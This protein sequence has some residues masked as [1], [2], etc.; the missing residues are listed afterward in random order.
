[1][2]IVKNIEFNTSEFNKMVTAPTVFP[3]DDNSGGI[4]ICQLV[5]VKGDGT[6]EKQYGT[7]KGPTLVE[8]DN[9]DETKPALGIVYVSSGR[10]EL[11]A[12]TTDEQRTYY[13]LGTKNENKGIHLLKEVIVDVED[14]T[15]TTPVYKAAGKDLSDTWSVDTGVS[16]TTITADTTTGNATSVLEAGDYVI[17]D[18]LVKQILSVTDDDNV[19]VTEAFTADITGATLKRDTDIEKPIYLGTSGDFVKLEPQTGVVQQ[20]GTIVSSEQVKI[21]L[22]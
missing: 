12:W 20:V 2:A 13:P 14:D 8:A 3:A 7:D 16:D 10:Y 19:E 4:E 5:T 17:I 15:T 9:T 11:D 22:D 21:K 18:G 1:M 6:S